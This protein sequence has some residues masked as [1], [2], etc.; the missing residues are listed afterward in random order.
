MNSR[1]RVVVGILFRNA[2][3]CFFLCCTAAM[4]ATL[5]RARSAH[6]VEVCCIR[7]F[8]SGGQRSATPA[9]VRNQNGIYTKLRFACTGLP[10]PRPVIYVTPSVRKAHPTAGILNTADL[11]SPSMSQVANLVGPDPWQ[12]FPPVLHMD[13][14]S[15]SQLTLS[16]VEENGHWV[17]VRMQ[18]GSRVDRTQ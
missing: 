18:E 7:R 12:V 1:V 16:V 11:Q 3:C 10:L 9:Q 14:V 13:I 4:K 15:P 6:P 5:C 8:P 17:E 2:H